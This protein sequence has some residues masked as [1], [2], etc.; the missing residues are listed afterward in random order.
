M[1]S[2]RVRDAVDVIDDAVSFIVAAGADPAAYADTFMPRDPTAA[3]A[4]TWLDTFPKHAWLGY[5]DGEPVLLLIVHGSYSADLPDGYLETGTYVVPD[6][7]GQ[8]IAAA[9]VGD[10]RARAVAVVLGSRGCHLGGQCRG[11]TPPREVRL[12]DDVE[13]LVYGQVIRRS[14]GLVLCLGQAI[15]IAA[16]PCPSPTVSCMSKTVMITGAG[17]G[18]GKQASIA[19]AARGHHVIATTESDAQAAALPR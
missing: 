17:S 16:R 4:R 13:S 19:L 7:R 1:T 18:F 14:F 3:E 2:L 12:H 8:G 5:D 10:G 9:G 15:A 11:T 6:H